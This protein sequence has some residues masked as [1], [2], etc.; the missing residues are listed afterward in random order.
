MT[1]QL[2]RIDS[3]PQ[4]PLARFQPQN[5]AQAMEVAETLSRSGLLPDHLRGKPADV[6]ATIL[7]GAELG[8]GMMQSF[9]AIYLVKGKVGFYADFMMAKA[10]SHPR[11]VRFD[12]VESTSS[13][14]TFETEEQGGK[15][16]PLS[17]S[18]E[19]ARKQGLTK[20]PV[21]TSNP[22]AMLRARCISALVKLVYPDCFF[23]TYSMEEVEEIEAM[24]KELNPPPGRLDVLPAERQAAPAAKPQ[25]GVRATVERLKAKAPAVV[26]VDVAPGESE[27]DAM[28]LAREGQQRA[29]LLNDMLKGPT[30]QT[31]AGPKA[32]ASFTT[33]GLLEVANG[34]ENYLGEHPEGKHAVAMRETL[35]VVSI[36]IDRRAIEE[37]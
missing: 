32:I 35:R 18:M 1:A 29:K 33:D 8:L 20:N 9:R 21:Y 37:G 36:E 4:S 14:A 10:K 2:A 25:N 15:V 34:A 24:E 26:V 23:G 3:A 6:L 7:A 16:T 22:A 28:A 5:L 17:V 31:K 30:I 27:E 12:M 19:D 13:I 11:C